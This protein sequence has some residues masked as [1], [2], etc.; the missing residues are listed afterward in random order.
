M[1]F[2]RVSI[3][4]LVLLTVVVGVVTAVS[5]GSSTINAS[6][7]LTSIDVATANFEANS[8][9]S[10]NVNQQTV[11]ALWG[12]KD[13]TEVTARQ[14]A[15]IIDAQVELIKAQQATTAYTRGALVVLVLLAGIV[16]TIGGAWMSAQSAR[17]RDSEVAP[18]EPAAASDS[19]SSDVA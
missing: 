5:V 13:L 6:N 9:L 2:A 11:V 18:I 14:N 3:A 12:V 1:K 7:G 17:R 4:I 16:G 19:G 10:E 15:T 8:E